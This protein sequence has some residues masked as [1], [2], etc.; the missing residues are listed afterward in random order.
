MDDRSGLLGP[1][2]GQSL[3]GPHVDPALFGRPLRCFGYAVLF[4]QHIG[5][6]LIDAHGV[7]GHVFMIKGVFGEPD[8]EDG[9]LHGGIGVGQNGNPFVG[10]DGRA[11]VEV[12]TDPQLLDADSVPEIAHLAGNTGRIGPGRGFRVTA[13]VQGQVGVFRDVFDQIGQRSVD[14]DPFI[15]APDM[16]GT[17][18]PALPAVRVAHLEGAPAQQF[19]QLVL[20]AVGRMDDFAFRVAVALGQDGVGAVGG[21]NTLDFRGDEVGGFLPG[22]ADIFAFAAVLGVALSPLGSQSTRLRGYL[23]RLGE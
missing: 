19:H 3:D 23:M 15:H 10:M 22:D 13:P 17:P 2:A 5:F 9:Q 21:D 7:G 20:T 1:L 11:V 18:V 8:V 4:A 12:G 16:L 6:D 14:A